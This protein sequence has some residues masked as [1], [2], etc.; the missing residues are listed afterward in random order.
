MERDDAAIQGKFR[1]WDRQIAALQDRCLQA[2]AAD[3]ERLRGVL[4]ELAA[5]R[6]RAWSRWE[7]ARA[8]GMWVPAEDLRRF[9]EA[10][11][12]AEE[13]FGRAAGGRAAHEGA[14]AA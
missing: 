9:Q 4:A 14:R 5:A 11:R 2:P 3:G 7:L 13:A 1:A 8:G 12:E 6:E 10:M